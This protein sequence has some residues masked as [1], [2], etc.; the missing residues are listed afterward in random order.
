MVQRNAQSNDMYVKFNV[1]HT[2]S[3]H[4][5]LISVYI[6]N[7]IDVYMYVYDLHVLQ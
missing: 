4:Y 1:N 5:F 6:F 7:F 2:L 3:L